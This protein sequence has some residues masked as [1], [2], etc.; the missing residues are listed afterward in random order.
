MLFYLRESTKLHTSTKNPN[1]NVKN[2]SSFTVLCHS[3]LEY[4]HKNGKYWIPPDVRRSDI[5]QRQQNQ[6]QIFTYAI[7]IAFNGI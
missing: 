7:V 5:W 4:H 2:L 3:L 6:A 1:D